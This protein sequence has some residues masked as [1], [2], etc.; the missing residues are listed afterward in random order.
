[1]DG[2]PGELQLRTLL[3]WLWPILFL[4]PIAVVDL[5]PRV[6]ASLPGVGVQVFASLPGVRVG[7]AVPELVWPVSFPGVL[8]VTSVVPVRRVEQQDWPFL[9]L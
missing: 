8:A 7:D 2:S 5:L 9:W 1:M 4:S 3:P 6:F